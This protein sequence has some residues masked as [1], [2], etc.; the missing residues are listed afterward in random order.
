[1]D[2][3]QTRRPDI[4]QRKGR[5]SHKSLSPA[6]SYIVAIFSAQPSK[7][8]HTANMSGP[9]RAMAVGVPIVGAIFAGSYLSMLHSKKKQEQ[10]GTNPY[11]EQVVAGVSADI[12]PG[13]DLRAHSSAKESVN[14]PAFIRHDHHNGHTTIRK[15]KESPEYAEYGAELRHMVPP[16]Q[17]GR[18][19][20]ERAYT[21]APDYVK[22]YNKTKRPARMPLPTENIPSP[23]E[24]S[25]PVD[26]VIVNV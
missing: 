6:H 3:N 9:G 7:I 20:D 21:K 23:T 25:A 26:K 14:P 11:F 1:M 15:Y 13:Q 19:E 18:P 24:A 17:R 10:A 8:I 12:P 5:N 22:N 2:L 16:P 4:N